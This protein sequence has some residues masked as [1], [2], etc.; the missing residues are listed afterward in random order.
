VW[1]VGYYTR[2]TAPFLHSM[3][4]HWNGTRWQRIVAPGV[5]ASLNGVNAFSRTDVW[6]VGHYR[7]RGSTTQRSLTLHWNGQRWKR[8]TSP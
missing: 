1:A 2:P 7:V 6:A 4:L 8:I 5:R 3:S